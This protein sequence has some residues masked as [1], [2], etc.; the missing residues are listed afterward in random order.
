[1]NDKPPT[2]DAAAANTAALNV[3]LERLQ[4]GLREGQERFNTS[5]NTGRDGALHQLR[6]VIE[7]ISR[8]QPVRDGRMHAP[9]VAL[10][11]A[12]ESL[13]NNLVKPILKPNSKPGRPPDSKLRESVKGHAV[14]TARRLHAAGGIRLP[15][16]YAQ[17]AH[18]LIRASFKSHKGKMTRE[19]IAQWDQEI[20]ADVG[21]LG[22]AAQMYDDLT[23]AVSGV[24][25]DAVKLKKGLLDSLQEQ[26]RLMRADEE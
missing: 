17:V 23:K 1:M 10:H 21:R 20:K 11:D 6:A 19:T 7:F 14:F 15:Q 26:V 12:V 25:V 9:L 3:E 18:T 2:P 8:L 16:A 4:S 22:V 24:R 13:D 5:N